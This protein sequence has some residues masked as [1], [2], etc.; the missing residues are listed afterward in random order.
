MLPG[1]NEA[2]PDSSMAP[3]PP[4]GRP[5]RATSE[6][7]PQLGLLVAGIAVCLYY[8]REGFMPLDQSIVYDGAW[9]ILN[10][11]V[12][13]R[14]FD[15]PSGLIPILLQAGI[16]KI[17]GMNWFTY[18]LH[19]ALFNGLF[20]LLVYGLLRR[21]GGSP[22][23]AFLWALLSGAAMYPPM[24]TPY[25]EQHAYFFIMLAL[26]VAVAAA[27]SEHRWRRRL[28]WLVLPLILE[29]A[30]LSKQI[31]TAFGMVVVAYVVFVFARRR[32]G[33]ALGLVAAG[34][35]VVLGVTLLVA[36][37]LAVDFHQFRTYYY[38]LPAAVGRTRL[39][40][41]LRSASL[42]KN[43]LWPYHH[44]LVTG[45]V[46]AVSVSFLSLY[47]ATLLFVAA[48]ALLAPGPL[49]RRF[50][51]TRH[52]LVR[53]IP[54]IGLTLGLTLVWW[55]TS[56]LT[57][58]QQEEHVGY[59]FA[60][61]GLVYVTVQSVLPALND[62]VRTQQA[63]PRRLALARLV[64]LVLVLTAILD[65]YSFNNNVNSTRA[66]N[67]MLYHPRTA[68]VRL[69][70]QLSFMSWAISRTYGFAAEDFQ[71]L[72][73]FLRSR[74]ENFFVMGDASVLYALA[75]HPSVNPVLWFD[76]RLTI[77]QRGTSEFERYQDRLLENFRRYQ[78]RYVV[79]ERGM[80]W[81]QVQLSDFPR[82]IAL[83]DS[84]VLRDTSFGDE[85]HVLEL[86]PAS[87][88]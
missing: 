46:G 67:D 76:P 50:P 82:L 10:G 47:L 27:Q 53:A 39:H 25:M 31:P 68:N 13:W 88:S 2:V 41:L 61:V 51:E 70:D 19:A 11:Q 65:A 64:T 57:D 30:L 81:L 48:L 20:C 52:A 38:Q 44:T 60:A 5:D 28:L 7:L 86:A 85:L 36:R 42:L 23:P 33:E 77:P 37:G 87:G 35:V 83:L 84:T 1:V 24:G 80:T 12:P 26:V 73:E 55:L 78:V 56:L 16:F 8:A 66:V 21:L 58:N 75:G 54:Q 40:E 17:L 4:T 32:L 71:D 63:G 79:V 62:P 69:P 9:R 43:L 6:V 18:C 34:T 29:F 15:L 14:D 45:D 3:E 59:L 49:A 72:T 74:R 22:R